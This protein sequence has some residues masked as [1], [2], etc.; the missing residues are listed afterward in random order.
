MTAASL[1]RTIIGVPGR[2]ASRSDIVTAIAENSGGYLLAGTIIMHIETKTILT[3]EVHDHEVALAKAF[4]IAGSGRISAKEIEVIGEH[5]FCL[6][7]VGVGGS[8]ESA[9]RF[10]KAANALLECGGDGVKV[11]SAG[12]AHSVSGWRELCDD[13]QLGSMLKAFVTY[14]GSRG[15]FYSCG[16][17]NLGYP[18]CIVE[19]RI[20]PGDA[21][22][23]IHTFLGY[24]LAENPA[25]NS[26][27]TFS[28]A[29]EAPRYRLFR[30]ECTMF[31]ADDP[32]HNPFGIW[33]FAPA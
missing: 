28:V 23:L 19:A 30:E 22:T 18:D 32:F 12:S 1:P 16:M 33:K 15:K 6:Y 7:L 26:G 21:A 4:L 14:V 13:G 17:H 2:W 24:L 20:E 25:I 3:L 5:T 31:S 29:A 11:E 10:M 27:E 9:E 8:L